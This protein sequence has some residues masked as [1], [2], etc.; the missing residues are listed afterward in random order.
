MFDHGGERA[1]AR[2]LAAGHASPRLDALSFNIGGS[3]R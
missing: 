2:F 3:A 1:V